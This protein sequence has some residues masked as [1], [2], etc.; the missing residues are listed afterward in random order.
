MFDSAYSVADTNNFLEAIQ[1]VIIEE[2]YNFK[3]DLKTVMNS[4]IYRPGYPVLH[5]SRNYTTHTVVIKQERFFSYNATF[6]ER[7]SSS[8]TWYIPI[9]YATQS[10]PDF[11]DTKPDFWVTNSSME[12]VISA[13]SDEW[14]LFNKHQSGKLAIINSAYIQ[15]KQKCN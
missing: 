8:H 1:T 9:N 7:N 11:E 12:I 15:Q 5:V 10:K 13:G 14:I 6:E 4:W 3:Y 2:K